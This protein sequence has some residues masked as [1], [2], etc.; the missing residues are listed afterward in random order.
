MRERAR[1]TGRVVDRRHP[2]VQQEHTFKYVR[3]KRE[4]MRKSN[5]VLVSTQ[6]LSI[7]ATQCAWL[8]GLVSTETENQ[9]GTFVNDYRASF[10]FLE[11]EILNVRHVEDEVSRG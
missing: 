1:E 2:D 3:S 5:C 9:R 6:G 7:C 8:F 4:R 10:S 11:K